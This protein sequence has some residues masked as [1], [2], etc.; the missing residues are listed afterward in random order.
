MTLAKGLP[1]IDPPRAKNHPFATEKLSPDGSC[2]EF[3]EFTYTPTPPVLF[4]RPDMP[5][6]SDLPVERWPKTEAEFQKLTR[7]MIQQGFAFADRDPRPEQAARS[8]RE[9]LE[10][11]DRWL[12]KERLFNKGTR[13]LTRKA[14]AELRLLRLLY[15]APPRI[16]SPEG[17]DELRARDH[18]F[19]TEEPASDGNFYKEYV[20]FTDSP[21]LVF[22]DPN[23]PPYSDLPQDTPSP[24]G[25]KD[26]S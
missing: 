25:S 11:R 2:F 13:Q 23:R 10:T 12:R 24:P 7:G 26:R 4:S 15:P 18:P 5:P 9:E 3:V 20:E 16:E 14:A 19:A 17:H 6:Y 21:P 22:G 1:E 8:R